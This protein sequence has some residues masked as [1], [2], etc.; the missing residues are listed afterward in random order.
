[1]PPSDRSSPIRVFVR[2]H[3]PAIFAGEELRCT[4]TFKNTA[5]PPPSSSSVTSPTPTPTPTTSRVGVGT[6]G[7][8]ASA[9]DEC[10]GDSWACFYICVWV[11]EQ[12]TR[13]KYRVEPS[14]SAR[15]SCKEG[16]SPRCIVAFCAAVSFN[17][18]K[19]YPPDRSLQR[20]TTSPSTP[21]PLTEFKFP[22]LDPPGSPV[23]RAHPSEDD[24]TSPTHSLP[25]RPRDGSSVPT[26]N[27]HSVAPSPRALPTT[28]IAGTPRS[29]GEFYSLSNHSSE[30]LASEYV[31]H[32]NFRGPHALRSP[33]PHIRSPS[34]LSVVSL[35]GTGTTTST[36]TKQN[37]TE[38][39]M[40]GFAQVQGSFVLDG[41]LINLAP[42]ESVKRKAVLAGQGGGVVG[43]ETGAQKRD[44]GL[45]RRALGSWG[46]ITSS[47]GELLGGGEMSTLKEMRGVAN[48]KA[49]PLLSVPQSI[50]FV[51]LQL[52]PGESKSFEYAFNL[53]R[54]LPPSHRGK[55]IKISYSLVIGTQRPGGIKEQRVKTVEVPFRVL[56]SVNS[57]GEVLGHDLMAPYVLLRDQARVGEVKEGGRG[58]KRGKPPP[59]AEK[60]E[61][62]STKEGFLAY[63]DEL[64]ARPKADAVPL[65]QSSA[66][67]LLSPT[68]SHLA[69][70]PQ[71]N[72]PLPSPTASRRPSIHSLNSD[73]QLSHSAVPLTAKEAID[74]A[75][76]RSARPPHPGAPSTTRFDIARN[77]A[78]VAVITLPRPAYRLGENVLVTIDFSDG[79]TPCYAVHCSLETIERVLDQQ[80]ALR[81]EASVTRVTRKVWSSGSECVLFG[82]R[83]VFGLGVPSTATPGFVT[84]AVGGEWRV[85]V[86]FVVPPSQHESSSNNNN[87]ANQNRNQHGDGQG[88]G[89]GKGKGKHALLEEISR[90]E[91]G[92]LVMVGVENLVCESFEVVVPLRVYGTAGGGW[93]REGEEEGL[94]V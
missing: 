13:A 50:L 31:Q 80:L 74:L 55:A 37:Q 40:M 47:I 90:D 77:G 45:F 28:S 4:I 87:N 19:G 89:N 14:P 30:T 88:E 8:G 41:S 70:P 35:P 59:G 5:S 26:I 25:I 81:S 33:P 36:G 6:T 20:L 60:K 39:L 42:F 92:G 83:A 48:S 91:K 10:A 38:T 49:I 53:P 62:K 67:S 76:L 17:E 22:R 93:E 12:Y 44:S 11:R 34:S 58:E 79:V 16:A 57:Y 9:E 82:R 65:P 56:G 64:L 54:G 18:N 63:V 3:D 2:W 24:P 85:R 27:E 46:S 94:V 1:M 72:Q 43:L 51:D 21:N 86:E 71:I 84:S 61:G 52:A 29:S 66:S 73:I 32:P 69:I 23:V 15:S 68:S 78:R 7:I 75:I